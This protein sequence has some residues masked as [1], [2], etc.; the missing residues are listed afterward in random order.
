MTGP[1]LS[2]GEGTHAVVTT[3]V[4]LRR[5][6]AGEAPIRV[7]PSADVALR[8]N[9]FAGFGTDIVKGFSVEALRQL[10]T[11]NSIVGS[12]LPAGR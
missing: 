2:L 4:F 12:E 5:G 1:A 6:A 8:R 10:R 11:T 9:V 3:S 7:V